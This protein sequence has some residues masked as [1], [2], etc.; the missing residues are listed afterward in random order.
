M[1]EFSLLG[2]TSQTVRVG[3]QTRIDISLAEDAKQIDAVVVEV[4]YGSQLKRDVSGS[5]GIVK[6]DDM[7][8]PR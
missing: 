8:R 1:L 4:G 2:Y 3:T 5:V 7:S 6:V